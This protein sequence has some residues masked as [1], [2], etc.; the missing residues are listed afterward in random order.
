MRL[1]GDDEHFHNGTVMAIAILRLFPAL[2]GIALSACSLPGAAQAQAAQA[3]P[4]DGAVVERFH[5]GGAGGWDFLTFD[6]AGQRLFIARAD[7]VQVWSARTKAVVAEIEG[8]AGVHGVA[9][10]PELHRGYTSNGRANTVSVFD[11]D[12]LRITDTVR[13]GENPDAIL[14]EPTLKRIYVF[15]GRDGSATV[16]D[17]A[18]LSV[19]A[20]VPLAGKPEVAFADGAGRVFVNIKDTAEIAVIDPTSNRVHARW[21]LKPCLEPTGMAIDTAHGRLFAV[22]SNNKMV[23]VDAGSGRI[24]AD[25]PIGS[26]PDGV[27]FDAVSGRAFSSNGQGTV[28]VV[29]ETDPEH[30]NVVETIP[31]QARARTLALDPASHSIYLVTAAFGPSPAASAPAT[32]PR[33]PMLKDTFSVLVV[34]LRPEPR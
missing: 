30:F 34:R 10:A 22:C 9:L 29:R 2:A 23:V 6:P 25:L 19:L 14:Y 15:N 13:V 26:E 27:E 11:L 31:T 7:R 32:R 18:T 33:P 28:T 24:V 4:A 12:S 3:I 1:R 17:A 20:T 16:I 5:V 21:P 8:T